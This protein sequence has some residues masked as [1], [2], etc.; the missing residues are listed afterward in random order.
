M[1]NRIWTAKVFVSSDV[2]EITVRVEAGTPHG[3]ESQIRAIYGDVQQIYNLHEV[4]G[5]TNLSSGG[6]SVGTAGLFL[7]GAVLIGFIGIFGGDDFTEPEEPSNSP[8]SE[9][10]APEPA[11]APVYVPS[12]SS[13]PVYAAEP[14]VTPVWEMDEDLTGN[15]DY[16]FND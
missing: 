9:Y 5:T 6:S 4:R 15:P 10:K 3:A 1:S 16:T 12:P 13:R 11:R 7:L 8:E 14:R 2:G